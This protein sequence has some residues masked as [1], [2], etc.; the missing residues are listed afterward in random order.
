MTAIKIC[1][2]TRAEDAALAVALGA[3]ALGFVL[4][5]GSPRHATVDAAAAIVRTLPPFVTPVGV[6]VDPSAEDLARAAAAGLRLAQVHGTVP[7]G[8]LALPVLRAVH[9]SAADAGGIEPDV[10]DDTVLL[11]AHDPVRHGG[12]G[13]TV[14]WTRARAI[15][16]RRRIVLAGGLTPLNVHDAIATVRPYGVDVASGVE[17]RPGVKDHELLRRFI[18]AAKETV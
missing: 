2:I 4:W 14:D 10:V 15:A 12:T 9:L 16:A 6:F 7:A 11:D 17:A 3:N 8:Q 1:G 13:R 18:T 5:P